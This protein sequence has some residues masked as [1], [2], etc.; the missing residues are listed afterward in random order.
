MKMQF[1]HSHSPYSLL[2]LTHFPFLMPFIIIKNIKMDF[3]SQSWP[4]HYYN[5][6]VTPLSLKHAKQNCRHIHTSTT[7]SRDHQR[8]TPNI[9]TSP[10]PILSSTATT[11]RRFSLTGMATR[12]DGAY[13]FEVQPRAVK[14]RT[15]YRE[16]NEQLEG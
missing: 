12:G 11:S 1:E 13:A 7:A 6:I 3:V 4:T 2:L 8:L 5:S 9:T 16:M 10:H 15:A 14:K